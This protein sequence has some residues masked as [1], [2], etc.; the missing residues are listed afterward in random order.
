MKKVAIYVNGGIIQAI[1]S[2]VSE[3]LD[4]EIVDEDNDPE[5]AE[6]RWEELQEELQFGNY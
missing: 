6:T 2:N 3:D 5:T 4:I 1:R